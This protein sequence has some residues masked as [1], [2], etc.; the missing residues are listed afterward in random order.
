MKI[1]FL[2]AN[3][4]RDL[5]LEE[6]MRS[7]DQKILKSVHRS[8]ELTPAPAVR[9]GDLIGL[10][11]R[12]RPHIVHFSGHG[13]ADGN[14]YFASDDGS[15][16][17]VDDVALIAV[18][19]ACSDQIRVVVLSACHSASLAES[20]VEASLVE[21]AVGM[22]NSI[23]DEAASI[24]A[25]RFYG[26]LCDG[27]SVQRAFDQAR[28]ELTLEQFPDQDTPVLYVQSGVDSGSIFLDPH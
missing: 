18:L 5:A 11:N 10:L 9:R 12:H 7:I 4:D 26:S 22:S 21:C 19:R 13:S 24:F 23:G 27:Q 3:V 14:I 6:E 8:L 25:A 15:D 28:A 16:R 20:L 1:L 2:G 17:T